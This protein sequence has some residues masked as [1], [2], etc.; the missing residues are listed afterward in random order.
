MPRHTRK[1]L[2]GHREDRERRERERELEA[3]AQKLRNEWRWLPRP[4]TRRAAA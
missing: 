4:T 2:V 3:L 1:Q